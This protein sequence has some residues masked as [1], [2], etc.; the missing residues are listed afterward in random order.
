MIP[1]ADTLAPVILIAAML[2][3]A[4]RAQ[5]R[6]AP[7]RVAVPNLYA[8]ELYS[9]HLRVFITLVDLPGAADPASAWEMSYQLHYVSEADFLKAVKA[10]PR[11]G[12][13]PAPADFGGR[14]LLGEGRFRRGPLTSLGD[15]T[16]VSPPLPFRAKV[17]D[18]ERTKFA[19][20]LLSFSLK[21]SDAGLGSTVYRA[22]TILNVPFERGPGGDVA[23]ESMYLSFLIAP[24][25][26]IYAS[27]RPRRPDSTSWP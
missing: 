2:A 12:W 18:R 7:S 16:F 24:E 25:G 21:V 26:Q 19:H 5:E 11:G 22:G 14:V 13:D 20:L 9:E 1:L 6:A 17:A 23:R 8:P 27:T 3:P 4:A 10:R 15:R